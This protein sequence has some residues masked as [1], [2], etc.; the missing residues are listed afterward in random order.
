MSGHVVHF[1]IPADDMERAKRFYQSAFGWQLTTMPGMDYTMV[2]TVASNDQGTPTEPGA[3]NGGMFQRQEPRTTP[4]VTVDVADIDKA[5][6]T[7]TSLGGLVALGK[8][9]VMG[10]GFTAYFTDTEG[11]LMGLWQNAT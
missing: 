9:D 4:I 7:I 8:Q 5:L 11:N 2:G 10:M 6:E 1:E 3:I